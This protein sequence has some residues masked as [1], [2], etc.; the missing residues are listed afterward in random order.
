MTEKVA[1][2]SGASQ[3]IGK[4]TAIKL[5]ESF[6]VLVLVARKRKELH[7]TAEAISRLA[8]SVKTLEL[9]V[10]LLRL[11]AAEQVVSTTINRFGRID[12]V[13]NI[14]GA[15]PQLDPFKMTEEQWNDGLGLKLGAARRL[16]IQSWDQLKATKGSVIFM[17]GNSALTPKIGF[18]AVATINAAILA[19]SKAM[20]DQGNKDGI[21]VNTVLPGAV[22]TDRRLN[23]LKRWAEIHETTPN[24]ALEVFPAETGIERYG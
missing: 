4:A 3:G 12:A 21:Q 1:I 23:Y 20:A 16:T 24:K 22:L 19:F 2:V 5:A 10:D 14:A 18:A 7:E 9:A 8:P 11:E 6:T 15:V 17:S 13:I